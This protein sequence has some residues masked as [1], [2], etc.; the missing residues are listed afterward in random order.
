MLLKRYF[1]ERLQRSN[2][3]D[4]KDSAPCL[5]GILCGSFVVSVLGMHPAEAVSEFQSSHATSIAMQKVWLGDPTTASLHWPAFVP[6]P[7]G[8]KAFV[9]CPQALP[10]SAASGAYYCPT[11]HEVLLEH[12]LQGAGAL[13]VEER[14]NLSFGVAVALGHAIRSH[15]APS[16]SSLSPPAS[17]LQATC[18]GGVLLAAS[19]SLWP[20]KS[21]P[22]LLPAQTAFP[23]EASDRAGGTAERAYALLSGFGGTPIT[24]AAP[25]MASLA[26]GRVPNPDLLDDL[27]LTT[28]SRGGSSF[29]VPINALCPTAGGCVRTISSMVGRGA[30][31]VR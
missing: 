25:L 12:R 18:L 4:G 13:K 2:Q 11:T 28:G 23:I 27:V 6:L 3:A 14:W 30:P 17:Q 29:A 22:W 9:R 1:V 16:P 15:G 5:V 20:G 31:P 19:P 8:Q 26:L 24:C 10:G 7:P 21:T